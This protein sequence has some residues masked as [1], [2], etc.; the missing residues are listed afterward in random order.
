MDTPL[1]TIIVPC[2]NMGHYLTETLNSIEKVF[3]PDIHEVIVVNDGSTDEKTLTLLREIKNFKVIHKEN[4]GLSSAR[5]KGISESSGS[6]LLF[7]DADNLLT[8]GYLTGGVAVLRNRQEIDIVYGESETFGN[9]TGRLYTKDYNLQTLM[10]YNY[11]DACCLVRKSLFDEIG[12][13]DESMKSGYEDWE[14]WLR[15]GLHNKKF[16]YLKDVV[17]Q[18]YRIRG[19]S[20]LQKIDK[21]KRDEIFDYLEKKYPELM[22]LSGVSDFYFRKFD[23]HPLGWT[24]KLFLKKYFP[25]LFNKLVSRGKISKYL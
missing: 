12:L 17:V 11:I 14:M 20:M 7:L 2:Y 6:Y 25:S 19:G 1:I 4:G 23:E 5:N 16:Y 3:Q 15:A 8:D 21:K 24:L 22:G 9:S 13:F 10:S 18:K